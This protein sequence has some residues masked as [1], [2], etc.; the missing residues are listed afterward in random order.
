LKISIITVCYNS[1]KTIEETIKSVISQNYFN[2]VQYII[3]D[4]E[5]SDSTLEIISKYVDKIDIVISEKDKGIYDAMNKGIKHATSN[6]IGILNSDDIFDNESVLS[7]VAQCFIEDPDLDILYGDLVYVKSNDLNCIVRFW[8]SSKYY[9]NYF[10]DGNVPP[11]PT[12]F[13][14]SSVYEMKGFF[15]LKYK[16]ASDYE[17]MLRI[18][19]SN[20]FKSKYLNRLLIRMRLG[21]AT[22]KN[23]KNIIF[24]NFEIYKSWTSNNFKMPIWFF[25]LRIFKKIKQFF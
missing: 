6:I 5:S 11:H 4:G 18:F 25:P 12:L 23:Y 2:N 3:V 19:K 8:K 16:L 17:F 1:S 9:N 24:G 22:N 13:I 10:E 15:D 14:K 7:D 21:G 20:I